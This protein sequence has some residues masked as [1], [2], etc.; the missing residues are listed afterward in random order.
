[1]AK[2]NELVI[3]PVKKEIVIKRIF[4]APREL[5]FKAWTDPEHLKHWYAPNNCMVLIRKF[6]FR[7]GGIFHH[8]IQNPKHGDCWAIG[9]YLEIV[10]PEKIVYTLAIADEKGN[11]MNPV[12]AGMDPEWPQ[13]TVVTV[14][15]EE[16]EGKTKLTLH[17]TVTESIAKRTGAYPSW[18]EML[19]KLAAELVIKSNI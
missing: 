4:N 13:E 9:T 17:Q 19:D 3:E 12:D 11:L 10:V 7:V 8:C 14:T 5:V 16:Y 2:E 1:M 15:F 18:L 6:D